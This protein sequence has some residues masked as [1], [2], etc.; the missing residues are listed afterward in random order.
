M[1]VQ[2]YQKKSK[3][4]NQKVINK[5]HQECIS[6]PQ[7]DYINIYEKSVKRLLSFPDLEEEIEEDNVFHGKA[8]HYDTYLESQMKSIS[9]RPVQQTKSFNTYVP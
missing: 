9:S 3:M 5:Y 4:Y 2:E 8:N 1:S 7:I 6:Y